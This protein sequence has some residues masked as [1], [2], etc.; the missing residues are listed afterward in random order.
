MN[1][2]TPMERAAARMAAFVGLLVIAVI[3]GLNPFDHVTLFWVGVLSIWVL[4]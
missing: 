2:Q 3:L 1:R 4:R